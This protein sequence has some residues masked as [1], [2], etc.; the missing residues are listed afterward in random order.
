MADPDP[1]QWTFEGGPEEFQ[2]FHRIHSPD[3]WSD[4]VH[5]AG[6]IERL[7]CVTYCNSPEL[8]LEFFEDHEIDSLELVDGNYGTDYREQLVGKP[9]VADRLETLKE[10]GDLVIWKA[11]S[12]VLHTKMYELLLEDGTVRLLVGSPN[13]TRSAVSN[14]VNI[15][16]VWVTEEESEL[17]KEWIRHYEEHKELSD[18]FLD[19]LTEAIESSDRDRE[20]VIERWVQGRMTE[21]IPELEA[22]QAVVE[23]VRETVD[24]IDREGEVPDAVE[25]SMTGFPESAVNHAADRYGGKP[26][27]DVLQVNPR[28]FARTI[29]EQLRVPHVALRPDER[30][31]IFHGPDD[32][33]V[34]GQNPDEADPKAIDAALEQIERFLASVDRFA[35]TD[36]PTHVKAHMY[37]AVLYILWAPFADATARL[38]RGAGIESTKRLP[39][40]Y[41]WGEANAGK[42]TLARYAY[43]LISP[44]T[45]DPKL[46]DGKRLNNTYVGNLRYASTIYPAVL[47]D[48]EKVRI[49][50]ASVLR[51]YWEEK[52]KQLDVPA[53]VMT[54]NDSRPSGWFRERAKILT[55]DCVFTSGLEGDRH[56]NRLI[57][58]PNPI[59]EWFVHRYLDSEIEPHDDPLYRAREI[60][61]EF[62][63]VAER[64]V[65]VYFPDEPAE[66]KFSLER[67]DLQKKEDTG[68]FEIRRRDGELFL[69][70]GEDIQMW[71]V[72]KIRKRLP[73]ACRAEAQGRRI[74]IKNPEAFEEWWRSE[75]SRGLLGRL[76]AWV[77]RG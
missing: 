74:L 16:A 45:W 31:V 63:E 61:R 28:G 44:E 43:D 41:I 12:K 47:S 4:V 40:L 64:D 21:A 30:V 49:E 60:L 8:V 20:E 54:S 55:F 9:Q 22:S 18:R 48:V 72:S 32:E 17:H 27:G 37:E 39:F 75:E 52:P 70:F 76:G 34:L 36:H 62:Y 10:S 19:D 68:A 57:E 51:N 46:V 15:V 5:G 38:Y 58:E 42:D 77:R 6:P 50:R 7:R 26:L 1:S 23:K 29:S 3:S 73:H 56:V 14:Q 25:V 67:L 35:V 65:P 69:E 2:G 53:I 66:E 11:R 59:F 13:L 33:H 71:T 24:P